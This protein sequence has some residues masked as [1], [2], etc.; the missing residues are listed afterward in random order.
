VTRLLYLVSHPIQYQAPLL[1][2]IAG[3]PGIELRVLYGD[4]AS[5]ALHREPEFGVDVAWDVPLLDGYDHVALA[6]TDLGREI[7]A[8]DAVWIHGWQY[9]WQRRAL[10]LAVRQDVP[11]LMR[12][13]NWSVAMPDPPG[14]LG[15][16]KR[17]W[18]RRLFQQIAGFL[19]IGSCNRDYYA[20][21]GVATDRLFSMP[22]AVD[23]AFFAA[24]AAASAAW[25][26]ELRH[27]LGVAPDQ[28]VL[29][30]VGKLTPRKS[31]ELLA[32]AWAGARWSGRP[33]ALVFVGDGEMREAVRRIAP[34]AV[35]AGFR[36]QS[37][38]PAF[39]G[40]ADLLVVPSRR[41]P[42]GLVVNEA[43]ACGTAV[44]ASDEVGAAH[45]LIGPETG[46]IFSAGDADALA[47]RLTD[48]LPRA[49]ALG[50]AARQRV[51]GWDFEEDVSGLKTALAAVVR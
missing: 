50:E 28:P 7:A 10:T 26:G 35:L 14:A 40:L 45:D 19:A 15:W 13:E 16:A 8:A 30:F 11:V 34:Q 17:L 32:A 25:Q 36:N 49:A 22:Y 24:R 46:A 38:L 51:A 42:W 6:S 2:R 12:G 1:R 33:P 9:P 5:A 48:C 29:L 44:V 21:H 47:A 31:P 39:Y 27:Q 18:R 43:M 20:A 3:E 41:E 23:N 37:E 4:R